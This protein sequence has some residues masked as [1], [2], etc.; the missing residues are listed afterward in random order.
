M[1][2]PIRPVSAHPQHLVD[3]IV[4]ADVVVV[5]ADVVVVVVVVAAAADVVDFDLP[6]KIVVVAD[7][8][9]V[10]DHR[11]CCL[12]TDSESFVVAIL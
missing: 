4:A 7:V 1:T 10:V 6:S 9:V 12:S 11:Y 8:E 3:A 5:A 2:T